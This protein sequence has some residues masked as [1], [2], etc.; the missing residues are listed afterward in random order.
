MDLNANHNINNG[1]FKAKHG[2]H[3]HPFYAIWNAMISRCE[4][5]SNKSFG[6]YGGRGI[7]VCKEWHDPAVFL[8]WLD[9]HNYGNGLQLD[10]KDNDLEYGPDNCRV[11]TRSENC[12]N[13]HDNKRYLVQGKML[14]PCEVQ[15]IYG[16]KEATFRARVNRYGQTPDEGII[17][18]RKLPV[19]KFEVKGVLMTTK[20][21]SQQFG[22]LASTFNSRVNRGWNA[23]RAALTPVSG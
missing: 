19:Y 20:E 21:I 13:R 17:N 6:R 23:K 8:D 16:I 4:N 7:T 1:R 22:I 15:E 18:Q 3:S 14:L 2:C 9:E 5:R 12:R 10:R 11:V